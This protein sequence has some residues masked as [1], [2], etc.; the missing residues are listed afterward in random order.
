MRIKFYKYQSLYE[1]SFSKDIINNLK[2]GEFILGK[3]IFKLEK[4]LKKYLNV[5]DV[6]TCGSATSALEIGLRNLNLSKNSEII[7]PSHTFVAT[8][9]SIISAGRSHLAKI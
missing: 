2:K 6:I 8:V 9:N 1:K 7:V 3:E 5:K 4:N